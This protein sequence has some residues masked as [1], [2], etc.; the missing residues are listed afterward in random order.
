VRTAQS[1]GHTE[2]TVSDRPDRAF[3]TR[4]H[5]RWILPITGPAIA[6]GTIV[7]EGDRIA[8]IGPRDHAPPARDEELGDAILIP[9]LVNAH[10]HLDLTVMRGFLEELGFFHWIRTLTAARAEL[11]YDDFLASAKLG[12]IE[13]FKHGVTTF[14]DTAPSP[15][16]LDA[17]RALGARGV[18]YREVFGPDPKQWSASLEELR[19]AVRAMRTYETPMVRVGVSPHA[20]YSV[21]DELFAAVAAFAEENHLPVTTHVAESEDESDLIENGAGAFAAFLHGRKIEVKPRGRSPIDMLDKTGI[22]AQRALL[23][24]CVRVSDADVRAI[25][26]HG[27]GVAHCPVSNAKLGHGVA[28]LTAFLDQNVHVGLGSDSM[29]SN[30]RMDL[31]AESRVAILAQRGVA[32]RDDLLT[33]RDALELATI[34]GARALGLGAVVGSLEVGKQ[35][36]FAAFRLPPEIGPYFDPYDALVWSG[37]GI[38]AD[39]VVIAGHERVRDGAVVGVNVQAVADRV[40]LAATRLAN[41][42]RGRTC[43]TERGR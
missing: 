39:R 37:G 5:A 31:L 13:G 25:A 23:I 41:W 28:P 22:L 24:H 8:W 42:K 9:G 26:A 14:A 29:A 17:M 12:V 38:T 15:A 20:P 7:V 34:G 35:A 1:P 18:A 3:R 33:A 10:T 19:R 43:E 2:K 4:Y 27:C 6:N 40:G 30:N 11:K 16:A 21:S 32:H 36:D